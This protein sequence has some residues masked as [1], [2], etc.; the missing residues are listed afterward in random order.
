MPTVTISPDQN[1]LTVD[2]SKF[3]FNPIERGSDEEEDSCSNCSAF[4]LCC[5]LQTT[6]ESEFP[7]PCFDRDDGDIGNFLAG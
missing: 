6:V 7:F 5:Q 3:N 4:E 2:E 1:I